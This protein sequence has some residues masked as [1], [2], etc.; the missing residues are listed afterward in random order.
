MSAVTGMSTSATLLS[1]LSV[2]SLVCS[3]PCSTA[4]KVFEYYLYVTNHKKLHLA[5][6]FIERIYGI[7]QEIRHFYILLFITST[8]LTVN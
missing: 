5:L 8:T 6:E 3:P 2:C 7:Y 4:D 1:F